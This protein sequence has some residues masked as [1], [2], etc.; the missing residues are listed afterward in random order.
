MT[1][2]PGKK[3]TRHRA[4]SR[5]VEEHGH[6]SLAE[7]AAQ[8]GVSVQTVRRDALELERQGGARR[9][10][11][12]I[13]FTG[14]L[15]RGVYQQRR[16]TQ[17][18]EKKIIADRIADLIPDGATVF[19]DIGTTCEAVALG[20]LE[21]RNLKIVTYSIRS[22]ML[23]DGRE[24]FTVAIPGGVVRH[25]D[26]AIIGLGAADFI[27]QFKFDYAIIAVS[28]M[29]LQGCLRDDDDFE[30]QRVRTAMEQACNI[31]LALTSNKIGSDGL[32]KLCDLRE[33][34]IIV[35]NDRLPPPLSALA[36]ESDVKVVSH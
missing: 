18:A 34:D 12:G 28:G 29:D 17:T 21:R 11:G 2:A 22:A 24:D 8:L 31:V 4:L 19:L 9:T 33:I 10:H 27:A 16:R 15:D 3:E 6:I 7:A 23:F 30:V 13:A 25:I 14:A 32:V 26:G 36:T 20:L 5:I 35:T 1:T